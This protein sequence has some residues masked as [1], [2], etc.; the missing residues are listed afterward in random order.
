[1]AQARTIVRAFRE[2]TV[3]TE[4]RIG[5]APPHPELGSNALTSCGLLPLVAET[6]V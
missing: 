5:K 1:M 2:L 6:R 3:A 4:R